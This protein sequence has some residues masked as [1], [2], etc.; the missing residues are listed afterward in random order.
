M[1]IIYT[2]HSEEKLKR[3]DIKKFKINKK[4]IKSILKDP[5][6]KSKTKYGDSCALSAI[7]G[8][9]DIRII[10]DI[11]SKDNSKVITFHISKRGRYG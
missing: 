8:D 7:N 4:L 9:H 10:Y 5:Q 3:R 2:Q 1:K 11:I 6:I